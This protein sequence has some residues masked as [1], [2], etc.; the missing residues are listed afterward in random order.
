MNVSVSRTNTATSTGCA[1]DFARFCMRNISRT[2][3]INNTRLSRATAYT[4][5]WPC[6]ASIFLLELLSNLMRII[7]LSV[8]LFAN[9]LAGHLIILFMAGGWP[10]SSASPA[11]GV[12]LLPLGSLCTCSRSAWWPPCR[13][14]SSPPS[15]RSTSA[16]RSPNP[17]RRSHI[18]ACHDP[19]LHLRR[20]R[21][22]R[23]RPARRSRSASAAASAPSAPASASASSSAR[24]SSRSPASRRCATRSRSIQWLGFALTE[25]CFFYGLVAGLHRLLPLGADEPRSSQPRRRRQLPA[26][27]ARRRADDLDA[28]RLRH[29]HAAA[30]EGRL[31]AHR[32][33]ARQAPARRSR[34]RSTRPSA[35]ASEA[36][37]LLAEYRERLAEAR[38]QADDI[39]ARARRTGRGGTR[40]RP[41]P[42][43]APSARR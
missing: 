39:V 12:F 41:S 5:T 35:R 11:L 32:R 38:G 7:S 8:R 34:T 26:S 42:R 31:P 13:R 22:R 4:R 28:D 19:E 3:W 1:D 18:S 16:A 9:M 10:S 17:T 15:P 36:D 20:R 14:S 37:E 2:P 29:H 21:R 24:S 30:L 40:P 43:R 33:G 25:A 23:R 27:S 6:I